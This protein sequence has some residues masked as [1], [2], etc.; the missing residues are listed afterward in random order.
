MFKH[1]ILALLL[2]FSIQISAQSY[3][4]LAV[5]NA[6]WI[7]TGY[8]DWHFNAWAFK[9]N[10]D[11]LINDTIY[12]KLNYYDLEV[13]DDDF[14]LP[15][16]FKIQSSKLGALIREDIENRKVYFRS[17]KL[18]GEPI[19]NDDCMWLFLFDDKERIL[20]DFDKTVGDTLDDCM[21]D[22][23]NIFIDDLVINSDSTKFLLGE[24][25]RFLSFSNDERL[26][27]AEGVGYSSGLF[28]PV[29]SVVSAE[30]G[31]YLYS[32]CVGSNWEC[33]LQTNIKEDIFSNEILI[34]PN[35]TQE[36]LSISS[37]N[38]SSQLIIY[39]LYGNKVIIENSKSKDYSLDLSDLSPGIYYVK[40]NFDG[41]ESHT[42]KIVKL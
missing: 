16:E 31:I 8:G 11:S 24:E 42:Q 3:K 19:I 10:G 28:N 23:M 5:E 20:F 29:N 14:E 21:L 2:I 17:L 22:T 15:K 25:R 27:L 41:H 6:T 33:E 18:S 38:R 1:F 4:P 7:M 35:P 9:I 40:L 36:Q 12:K 30:K 26:F 13:I 32:H 37:E 34:F 39:D